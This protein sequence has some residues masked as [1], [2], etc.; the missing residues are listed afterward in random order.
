MRPHVGFDE[1]GAYVCDNRL[2]CRS[3]FLPAPRVLEQ[4]NIVRGLVIPAS[5]DDDAVIGEPCLFRKGAPGLNIRDH[6][7]T[8]VRIQRGVM[9]N[10]FEPSFAIVE[11]DDLPRQGT[12]GNRGMRAETAFA[13]EPNLNVGHHVEYCG[14]LGTRSIKLGSRPRD[15]PG[16]RPKCVCVQPGYD[17]QTQAKESFGQRSDGSL[18]AMHGRKNSAVTAIEQSVRRPHQK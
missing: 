7:M 12:E 16:E 3:Q 11:H 10:K 4:G 15:I 8:E 9:A 13:G 2:Q 14:D 17:L 18:L 1:G 5:H 6:G